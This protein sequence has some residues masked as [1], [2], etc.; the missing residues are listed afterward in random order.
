LS[1]P[2]H[3]LEEWAATSIPD[4]SYSSTLSQNYISEETNLF[5]SLS[6]DKITYLK[7]IRKPSDSNA[8]EAQVSDINTNIQHME[9]LLSKI[10]VSS[11]TI[12]QFSSNH[13][14]LPE[15]NRGYG[16]FVFS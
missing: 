15:E 2:E 6:E 8:D 16:I 5:D 3:K 1:F 9:S 10:T 14:H 12:S 4:D 11:E 7:C 13:L